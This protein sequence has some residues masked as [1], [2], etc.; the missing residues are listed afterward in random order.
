M[1]FGEERK[2]GTLKLT[3][4]SFKRLWGSKYFQVFLD[5]A[6]ALIISSTLLLSLRLFLGVKH[7][8]LVVS[9]GSMMPTL[10]IGDLIVVQGAEP[11]QISIGDIVVFRSPRNPAELI[12]HR[13][14]K[15]SSGQGGYKITTVGDAVG[16]S[17]DQFSPW[18]GSLLVGRV[19]MRVPFIGN[20]YLFLHPGGT[21][22][23]VF[24][25]I[26]VI[27]I[28][29]L[30]A[31]ILFSD[32]EKEDEKNEKRRKISLE[33]FLYVAAVN[34]LLASLVFFSLWG[35]IEIWQPGAIPPQRVK[36]LGMFPDVRWNENYGEAILSWGFMTYR[37]DCKI[38]S[39]VRLGV[40]TLS[41][42][43][44][45]LLTLILFDIHEVFNLIVRPNQKKPYPHNEG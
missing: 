31:I 33:H 42:F 43:Q 10:N 38:G 6:L 39:S 15:I 41:W 28:V 5:I 45:F 9:S 12:V 34:L 1:S 2:D 27:A 14:V 3:K 11:P 13:V 24:T 35:Y 29:I 40:P 20:L 26:V 32:I 19:V 44:L 23:S 22:R 8:L 16:G 18:D 37:I 30:M 21:N 7:P 17:A 25:A 36:V 4:D